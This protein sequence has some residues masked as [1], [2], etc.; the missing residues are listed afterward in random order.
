MRPLRARR[1]AVAAFCAAALLAGCSLG[2][3]EPERDPAT[4]R[5]A[6]AAERLL[7]QARERPAPA[8]ETS[9]PESERAALTAFAGAWGRR[10]A[11]DGP[12]EL[13]ALS[14]GRLRE[15]LARDTGAPAPDV[16]ARAQEFGSELLEGILMR[17]GEP[18]LVV[19]KTETVFEE[20]DI[21]QTL[22]SV[23]LARAERVDGTWKVVQW[24][25]AN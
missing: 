6:A 24:T 25:S 11:P 22:Y 8:V 13:A 14:S 3:P 20:G 9:R 5:Q 7:E 2:P 15:A 12:R 19:T 17:P 16:A 18:A 10:T 1:V 21:P 23:Y 4:E